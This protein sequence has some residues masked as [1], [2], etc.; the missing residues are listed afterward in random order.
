LGF[1]S[2]VFEGVEDPTA[3]ASDWTKVF[4]H[5]SPMLLSIEDIAISGYG[6]LTAKG[7]LA[8]AKNCGSTIKRIQFHEVCPDITNAT[9]SEAV[10]YMKNLE[11]FKIGEPVQ[12]SGNEG[13]PSG[14]VKLTAA[15]G[16]AL[17]RHCPK[18]KV[19][20]CGNAE[21]NEM[22]MEIMN[23]VREQFSGV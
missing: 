15:M 21:V 5:V 9:L 2:D 22:I 1:D 4:E 23:A 14:G 12:V 20:D 8:I 18:L 17:A 3:M 10:K 6:V 19:F 13:G 7:L 16:V 11:S